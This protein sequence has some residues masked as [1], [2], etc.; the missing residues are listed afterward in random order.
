MIPSRHLACVAFSLSFDRTS[1]S[2]WKSVSI[3]TGEPQIISANLSKVNFSAANS[4]RNGLYFS[5]IFEV[6]FDANAMGC[7]FSTTFPLGNV[8][9]HFCDNTAAKPD[10]HL[11]EVTM[12]GVPSKRGFCSTGSCVITAFSLA[13]HLVW[14][15]FQCGANL[16]CSMILR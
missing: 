12:N 7:S 14:V 15:S 9:L 13:K 3:S 4:R 11:S 16:C 2:A 6:L 1:R 5:S 10:L 8:T